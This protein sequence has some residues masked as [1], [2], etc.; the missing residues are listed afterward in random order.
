MPLKPEKVRKAKEVAVAN[1]LT[2]E[3][4]PYTNDIMNTKHA[5]YEE[6]LTKGRK[7]LTEKEKTELNTIHQEIEEFLEDHP[8]YE[9]EK[10]DLT[11]APHAEHDGTVR[12]AP[13]RPSLSATSISKETQNETI[14]HSESEVERIHDNTAEITKEELGANLQSSSI[15]EE[16]EYAPS[17]I[18]K[19]KKGKKA[20]NL[21]KKI[22]KEHPEIANQY[23]EQSNEATRNRNDGTGAIS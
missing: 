16:Y 23:Q 1:V 3:R 7:N 9:F 11:Q 10:G 2:T 15:E 6:L 13:A 14:T 4:D 20:T 17:T 19:L 12:R 8:T 22:F 21:I 18:E 5:R